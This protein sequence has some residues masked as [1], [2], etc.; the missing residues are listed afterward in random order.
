LEGCCITI[1]KPIVPSKTFLG[2]SLK[3]E[4]FYKS[5]FLQFHYCLQPGCKDESFKEEG[6]TTTLFKEH[7][8][9]F[10]TFGGELTF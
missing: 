2:S 7:L 9:N 3:Q 4:V 5:L 10:H 1:A 8:D 6:Q